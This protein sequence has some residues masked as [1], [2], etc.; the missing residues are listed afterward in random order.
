MVPTIEWK[1]GVVRLL[2]QSLLPDKVEFVVEGRCSIEG[3]GLGTL[4]ALIVTCEQSKGE[5]KKHYV[6]MSDNMF[7]VS[8]QL[9]AL[10]ESVY[11]TKIILKPQNVVPDFDLVTGGG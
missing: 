8:T 4:R 9:K 5:F 6:G 11:H 10:P 2:D 3:D 7:F 1:D